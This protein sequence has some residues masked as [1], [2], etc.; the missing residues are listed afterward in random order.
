MAQPHGWLAKYVEWD[1]SVRS[2]ARFLCSEG[3]R[4]D[5]G[6]LKGACSY[7]DNNAQRW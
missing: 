2:R 4:D 1:I 5:S 6:R 3:A 7:K